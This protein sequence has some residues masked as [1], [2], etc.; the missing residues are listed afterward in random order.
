MPHVQPREASAVDEYR[1]QEVDNR[2]REKGRLA[3]VTGSR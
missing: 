3:L 2:I 1:I